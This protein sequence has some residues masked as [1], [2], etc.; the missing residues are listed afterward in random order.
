MNFWTPIFWTHSIRMNLWTPSQIKLTF[1]PIAVRCTE[2]FFQKFPK[3]YD[4][5]RAYIRSYV[6]IFSTISN[7]TSVCPSVRPFVHSSVRRLAP[8]PAGESQD[9]TNKSCSICCRGDPWGPWR[10]GYTLVWNISELNA[11]LG[12]YVGMSQE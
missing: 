2:I 11:V 4:R 6:G 5:N 7:V 1:E 3:N 8:I 9:V 12:S 10:S